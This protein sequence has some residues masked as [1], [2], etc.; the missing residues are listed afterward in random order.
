MEEYFNGL[1]KEVDQRMATTAPGM[2]GKEVI[3][4]CREMVSYLKGKNRELKE[5][6]LAHP[7]AGD[8]KEILY[9]KYYKPALTGRLLYYYR[10]YQ[11]ESGC[12]ACLRVAE[13]YYRKAMERAERMMERY[14]PF[15]QYYHS[16]ATYRDSY[17][18][19]RAKGELSPESGSFVLDE[20]AEFSTGYDILAARLISVEMLLVHLSRRM[21][22][23]AQGTETE[24]VPE[25]EHRWTNTKVAA[26]LLVYGIHV[27][28]SVD[29]GNAEIGE[30][31]ALFEKH[32]HVDLGN[33]Y[34]AFGRLRGQQNPT[35]FLDEACLRVAEPYY[36]KAMER[37]ERMMERYLPFY[38]YYHSGATYR[39]SYYFLRA[40]GELSPESGSFVLDEEAEFSTGYDILAA[41]LISVEMLLVHLS[42]R[43]ERAAQGTETE[44]VPEKEHRWTNTKVA[45]ILLVYGIH[46]TGSV[47]EGNAEI[48]ELAALFEKHFHVDLGNVY[49][50]FGR[51]RGQQNPTAFLDEM[52]ERLLKKMRDMDS[53]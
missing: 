5:Y 11:I 45:A 31:A 8:A 53:R 49:H 16:G 40:K 42:R 28:G 52:K 34:H 24:A 30:L 7:F 12:P 39:D 25:K 26:I 19:L 29:E 4:V 14:L 20:E 10:V 44:A 47:D 41:R 33:V 43:M 50:A 35:A 3:G 9:F 27:T 2:D 46:V 1:L 38:Q 6:A 18:F 15:Y 37:A 51:L 23:A 48:G 17:Y 21:E 22:R 32:F 36:R 13:P